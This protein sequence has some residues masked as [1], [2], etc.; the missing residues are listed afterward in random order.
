M[1]KLKTITLVEHHRKVKTLVDTVR[2]LRKKFD[3]GYSKQMRLKTSKEMV[4]DFMCEMEAGLWYDDDMC[5]STKD[6]TLYE[7]WEWVSNQQC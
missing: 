2:E 7:Y 4:L 1:K 5:R 3:T 6:I